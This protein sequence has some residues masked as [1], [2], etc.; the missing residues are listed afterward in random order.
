MVKFDHNRINGQKIDSCP[1]VFLL[2]KSY[3][4]FEDKGT[5]VWQPSDNQERQHR[6]SFFAHIVEGL[7]GLG[8]TRYHVIV[9]VFWTNNPHVDNGSFCPWLGPAGMKMYTM[10]RKGKKKINIHFHLLVLLGWE[11]AK[12]GLRSCYNICKDSSF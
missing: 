8:S 11:N 5:L 4:I 9:L 3:W 2:I 1:I 10:W 7:G 6:S 12:W